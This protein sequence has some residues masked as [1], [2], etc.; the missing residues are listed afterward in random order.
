MTA[1]LEKIISIIAPHT[2]IVCGNEDNILCDA[3]LPNAFLVPE[4]ACVMCEKPTVNWQI[5]AKC[6]RRSTLNSVY[7]AAEYDGVATEL[8]KLYKFERAKAAYSPL[9]KAM[10]MTLP[11]VEPGSLVVPLPTAA[12]RVRQRGYDQSV[13]LARKLAS[14]CGLKL[15]FALKRV[16][17]ARQVGANRKDRQVQAQTAYD[18][19]NAQEVQ[20]K[21]VWLVDDICTTGASLNASARLMRKAGA[22]EVNA[23]VVAWQ[24]LK[25]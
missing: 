5:C 8:L 13:L 15:G 20:G 17:T 12:V 3:C 19:I 7:V 24:R 1:L 6:K 2:C 16:G 23:V 25:S 14:L 22:K 10:A 21:T 18:L 4:S 9:A 11:Y